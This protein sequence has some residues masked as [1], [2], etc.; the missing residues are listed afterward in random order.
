M[1]IRD[2]TYIIPIT[3]KVK[4]LIDFS[5]KEG[6]V[7]RVISSQKTNDYL[8]E[9]AEIADLKKRDI[10]YPCARHTFGTE[11]VNKGVP[12][13]ALKV[14]MGHKRIR[15]TEYYARISSRFVIKN[16][17]KLNSS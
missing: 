9:I 8:K 1:C 5:K 13:E 16:F 12:L 17:S 2:R 6:K 10:T 4:R 14:M 15:T 11:S 7:Y 3:D